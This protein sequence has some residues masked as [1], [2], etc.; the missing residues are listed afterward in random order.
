MG[1]YTYMYTCITHIKFNFLLLADFHPLIFWGI[2]SP[3]IK[4][5]E[6]S[7]LMITSEK[8]T[9]KHVDCFRP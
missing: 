5:A 8:L 6:S 7:L 1:V 2:F 9:L 3:V 4:F